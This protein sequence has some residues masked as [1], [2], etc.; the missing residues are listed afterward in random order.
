MLMAQAAHAQQHELGAHARAERE[1]QPV[2]ARGLARVMSASTCSTAATTGCP[3]AP[4]IAQLAARSAA[5]QVE[6]AR[7]RLEH[8]R[9]ARMRDPGADVADVRPWSASKAATIV[10]EVPLDRVGDAGGQHDLEAGAADVP[11]DDVALSG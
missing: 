2:R 5:R 8:A 4:A 11:A 1:Q 6:R 7:E 10:R 3:P 9:A